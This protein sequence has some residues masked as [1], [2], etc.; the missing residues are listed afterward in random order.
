VFEDV[1]PKLSASV[2]PPIRLGAE[3]LVARIIAGESSESIAADISAPLPDEAAALAGALD[4]ATLALLCGQREHGLALQRD[5]LERCAVFRIAGR[6][7]GPTALR[8][9]AFAAP[10]DLQ[11][12]MPIE[13]ITAHLDIRLD[14]L[15]LLPDQALPVMVPDH[16]VAICIVSDSDPATLARLKP[17]LRRWPRPVLNPP[18]RIAGGRLENLT[19]E[20]IAR[21]F[22]DASGLASVLLAPTTVERSRETLLAHLAAGADIEALIPG[23]SWP[24]LV[25]PAG[26][27]AGKLLECLHDEEELAIYA[28]AISAAQFTLT[29]FIDY[30]APDGH[31]RKYR[32]ALIGGRPFLCHMAV[33]HHWMIHYLNAG[34]TESAEK[35]EDEARA[36]AEF[37]TGFARR[38]AAALAILHERLGLDYVLLDCGEAPDGRLLLFEVEMAAI[39]HLLDPPDLFPYKPKQMQRVFTAFEALLHT[40]ARRECQHEV[41]MM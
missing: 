3:P 2:T 29:R 5:V 12:N 20:G 30:R 40:A 38:H 24:L 10:G 27:H 11:M 8:L 23:G 34:M 16:D 28:D 32:I 9:L 41:K 21:L 13:F 36:M 15:T 17:L 35:R 37:D 18:D 4:T 25:R 1:L 22:A 31:Y 14:V 19:R 7:A 33:S 39:I 26:S 6:H